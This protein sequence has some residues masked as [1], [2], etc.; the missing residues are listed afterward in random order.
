MVV[1]LLKNRKYFI[2]DTK[3]IIPWIIGLIFIALVVI[4]GALTNY[5]QE[6]LICS[7]SE[8]ICKIEK[9][10]LVNMK[11]TKKLVK[12][13]EVD[14]VSY[15]RQKVK[16]NRYAK[17]YTEYLLTFTKKDNNNVVIFSESYFEK[18]DLLK[19]IRIIK[20]KMGKTHENFEFQREEL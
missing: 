20:E 11:S 14:N 13:S 9:I 4:V 10:N 16:G 15:L 12:Y 8:N 2:M 6:T 1:N 19:T 17:G 5:K 3:K 18:E 7:K